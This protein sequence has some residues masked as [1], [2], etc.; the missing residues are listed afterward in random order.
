[1]SCPKNCPCLD[2]DRGEEPD[3]SWPA[4]FG[5]G[6]YSAAGIRLSKPGELCTAGAGIPLLTGERGCWPPS[7]PGF[8]GWCFDYINPWEFLDDK[9]AEGCAHGEPCEFGQY[10]CD[11]EFWGTA[12]NYVGCL[13]MCE[14]CSKLQQLR[15]DETDDPED[16]C[17]HGDG[18][19]WGMCGHRPHTATELKLQ[20]WERRGNWQ[21]TRPAVDRLNVRPCDGATISAAGQDEARR[22]LDT[23]RTGW[24]AARADATVKS[25]L[26]KDV[27]RLMKLSG[28]KTGRTPAD[29]PSIANTPKSRMEILAPV[30]V[31]PDDAPEVFEAWAALEFNEGELVR[32]YYPGSKFDGTTGVIEKR[33]S[34]GL[35]LVRVDGHDITTVFKAGRVRYRKGPL[36]QD[37]T[38]TKIDDREDTVGVFNLWAQSGPRTPGVEVRI[39]H[40][41]DGNYHDR[42]GVVAEPRPSN[43][44]LSVD[45]GGTDGVHGFKPG[46]IRNRWDSSAYKLIVKHHYADAVKDEK[47]M[48][49]DTQKTLDPGHGF[50]VGDRV[51]HWPS[52]SFGTIDS[53]GESITVKCDSAL[54]YGRITDVAEIDHLAGKTRPSE[55]LTKA[56]KQR[57]EYKAQASTAEAERLERRWADE[58]D[59]PSTTAGVSMEFVQP[60]TLDPAPAEYEPFLV[61]YRYSGEKDPDDTFLDGTEANL[62]PDEPGGCN[63]PFIAGQQIQVGWWDKK[64]SCWETATTYLRSDDDY[65]II[66]V[67]RIPT[68]LPG[69]HSAAEKPAG[70]VAVTAPSDELQAVRQELADLKAKI[71]G[72]ARQGIS[73]LGADVQKRRAAALK[74]AEHILAQP[75]FHAATNTDKLAQAYVADSVVLRNAE[76]VEACGLFFED[77][78]KLDPPAA[79]HEPFLIMHRL[80]DTVD[81][82]VEQ[83]AGTEEDLFPVTPGC[84][85]Q[86][87]IDGK[88]IQ[89][90]WWG[91]RDKHRHCWETDAEFLEADCNY[92]VIAVARIPATL[93]DAQLAYAGVEMPEQSEDDANAVADGELAEDE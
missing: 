11:A 60:N 74:I 57:D 24:T 61:A 30:A 25:Q 66:A 59:P 52:K 78:A 46:R 83:L 3:E 51:V 14:R 6:T 75:R 41:T 39:W 91:G 53:I 71:A 10:G 62:F 49:N 32:I 21:G 72:E 1:M 17:E 40:P 65:E 55:E 89:L 27:E 45:L 87:F 19:P 54:Y 90:G 4:E 82:D 42:V 93:T 56:V 23:L 81:D 12:H 73:K 16:W 84:D 86:P 79:K 47:T 31:M 68:H 50:E 92:E 18:G 28:T 76:V 29:K 44:L 70:P 67:A 69:E 20:A 63:Q 8:A 48:S 38:V 26:R 7:T 33:Y 9:S 15:R 43:G 80:I 64:R 13:L 2:H 36:Q 35:W 22:L 77:P 37:Q 34:S 5:G 58:R 88:R 85:D